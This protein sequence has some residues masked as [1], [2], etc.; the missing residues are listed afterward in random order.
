MGMVDRTTACAPSRQRSGCTARALTKVRDGGG[1]V[2]G[3]YTLVR[4]EHAIGTGCKVLQRQKLTYPCGGPSHALTCPPMTHADVW[5]LIFHLERARARGGA[6]PRFRPRTQ[7]VRQQPYVLFMP[8]RAHELQPSCTG[9]GRATG[10]AGN[11]LLRTQ[12]APWQRRLDVARHR[13]CK[14]MHE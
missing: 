1:F 13:H 7:P 4:V 9:S 2:S 14:R 8:S 3:G 10:A 5:P 12:P 6:A 11:A